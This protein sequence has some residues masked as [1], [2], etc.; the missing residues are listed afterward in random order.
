MR[1]AL[2]LSI[3]LG[4]AAC[5]AEPK[6]TNQRT[7]DNELQSTQLNLPSGCL[8]D[9]ICEIVFDGASITNGMGVFD[10]EGKSLTLER[11][12]EDHIKSVSSQIRN[13]SVSGSDPSSNVG[14]SD[15]DHCY[16]SPCIDPEP[17]TIFMS[18]DY[19][20]PTIFP[21]LLIP[22]G[23]DLV[24][25]AIE[26]RLY[27]FFATRVRSLTVRPIDQYYFGVGPIY[28]YRVGILE[29]YN[30]PTFEYYELFQR[31]F[32][33]ED[34]VVEFA[35][36]RLQLL[37][38]VLHDWA[39]KNIFGADIAVVDL[40]NFINDV[41]NQERG[42]YDV[43]LPSFTSTIVHPVD[44]LLGGDGLHPNKL[45]QSLTLNA[46]LTGYLQKNSGMY[47]PYIPDAK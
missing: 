24:R 32:P 16:Q 9:F 4:I 23:D 5:G 20:F 36:G 7:L 21:A 8:N 19:F 1:K 37:T 42:E 31:L 45:G 47:V 27:Q 17:K 41:F 35:L 38:D 18:P 13:F 2:I 6:E 14:G 26:D 39:D 25:Q 12:M 43:S 10:D 34:E 28:A 46:L 30:D 22:L 29:F 40:D 33:T 15:S 11:R 3:C 44:N